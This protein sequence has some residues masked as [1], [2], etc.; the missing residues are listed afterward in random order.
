MFGKR[1]LDLI[2]LCASILCASILL[3]APVRA[4]IRYAFTSNQGS[5]I[6]DSLSFF[7]GG[8]L[9]A[10]LL[11]SFSGNFEDGFFGNSD[12]SLVNAACKIADDCFD[13][14]FGLSGIFQTTG[15]YFASDGDAK[16]VISEITKGA[17]IPELSS[18]ALLAVGF[19]GLAFA[20][21]RR[22][23][24]PRQLRR[25]ILDVLRLHLVQRQA[26]NIRE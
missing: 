17:P 18:W 10:N 11:R 3:S 7:E 13:A 12:I 1:R 16:I 20:R 14:A 8:N 4:D 5:F 6:Y 26:L 2:A 25:D 21:N 9:P 19:A 22:I 15:T 24:R 23:W